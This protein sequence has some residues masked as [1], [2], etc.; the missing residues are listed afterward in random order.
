MKTNEDLKYLVYIGGA[1]IFYPL[2]KSLIGLTSAGA[3][4][5]TG[6]ITAITPGA[7]SQENLNNAPNIYAQL[8]KRPP[9]KLPNGA[10]PS[11]Q[12]FLSDEE[13]RSIA[14]EIEQNLSGVSS[15]YETIR[16]LFRSVSP[17]GV[18]DLRMI[19]AQFGTRREYWAVAGGTRKNLFQWLR[20]NLTT[21]ELNI[22]RQTWN[23]AN[24]VPTL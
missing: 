24:I 18:P 11:M 3:T 10:N 6:L 22:A 9:N 2:I 1:I 4:A 12:R 15:D 17:F 19:Y 7:I 5:T 16:N 8:M 23:P 13:C 20:D 14:D 21:E